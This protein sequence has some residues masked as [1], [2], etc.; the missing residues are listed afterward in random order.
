MSFRTWPGVTAI[1][2]VIGTCLR[3]ERPAGALAAECGPGLELALEHPAAQRHLSGMTGRE[4]QVC[5]AA[6]IP[7]HVDDDVAAGPNALHAALG[8][9]LWQRRKQLQF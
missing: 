3:R 4:S 7:A 9:R 6:F 2:F 8:P 1:E 5:Q